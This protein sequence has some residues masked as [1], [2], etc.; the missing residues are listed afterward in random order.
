MSFLDHIHA[1]NRWEPF[2]F[3]P[4]RID[5]ACVGQIRRDFVRHLRPWP[6]IFRIEADAVHWVAPAT[7]L[8]ERT[9]VLR[10]VVERLVDEGVISHLHGERYPVSS[11]GRRRVHLLVDR[12]CAPYF[13]IR[14]YGQH[15]NGYVR[16]SEGLKIWVGLRSADRRVYPNHLDNLVA[17][18]LPWG[19]SLEEN[20]LKECREEADMPDRLASRARA[21]SAVTYCR[22]S[23]RG[24]KPDVMY[25]YDLELPEDF[26]PRCNDGEVAAFSLQPLE[27][28]M[29]TV[30]DTDRFKLNCNLVIIDFLI[31]HGCI[32]QDAPDY[33]HLIHGLRSPLPC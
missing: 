26:E 25:C 16:T 24:L 12:A 28:V 4:F 23:E 29:E 32:S 18:G 13:G 22:E 1:C 27:Q 21:V 30:R 6:K 33:L 11:A 17:G 3:V 20:L 19:V 8:E 15:L 9:A 5:Q 7:G 2:R 31:R 14:A 10:E